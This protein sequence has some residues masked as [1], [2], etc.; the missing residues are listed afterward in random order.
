MFF[1]ATAAQRSTILTSS[2]RQQ[3][4]TENMN[5]LESM[6]EEEILA[7]RQKLLSTLDPALIQYLKSQRLDVKLSYTFINSHYQSTE[8]KTQKS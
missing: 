2:D 1:L 7:E 5:K 8:R 6:S 4:H 3:I